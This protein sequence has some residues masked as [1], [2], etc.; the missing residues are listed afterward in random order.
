MVSRGQ[1]YPG[2]LEAAYLCATRAL[3]VAA[4]SDRERIR[5]GQGATR[6]AHA[7]ADTLLGRGPAVRQGPRRG[8]AVR[9]A[10]LLRRE[11]Y[12]ASNAD[13][14][15]R[16]PANTT[17]ILRLQA[18]RSR[19]AIPV[20]RH[21]IPFHAQGSD[22]ISCTEIGFRF[23][24]FPARPIQHGRDRLA[25]QARSANAPDCFRLRGAVSSRFDRA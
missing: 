5:V 17:G 2:V 1:R 9:R 6:A 10:S 18:R 4:D 13:R 16:G 14:A 21:R 19:A 15:P 22:S 7:A 12:G 25:S 11:T 24:V 8:R 3:R 23:M 20:H